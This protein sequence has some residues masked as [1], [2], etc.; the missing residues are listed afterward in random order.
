[1]AHLLEKEQYVK[2][3]KLKLANKKDL[4]CIGRI[5]FPVT[6]LG[7]G[8]RL[9]IW[10]RGC[11]LMCEECMS[12]DLWDVNDK[13]YMS[14]LDVYNIILEYKN[15]IDGLTISGGEPF[16]QIKSLLPLIKQLFE[17]ITKDIILYTGY[18]VKELEENYFYEYNEIKKYISVLITGRYIKEMNNSIGLAGSS[19]QEYIT[20]NNMYTI[21]ELKNYKREIN[22]FN[23][24]NSIVLVGILNAEKGE[25]DDE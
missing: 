22:I 23:F 12:K 25:N 9:V 13:S 19:N 11:D 20:M 10:L 5:I 1:M 15:K 18:T 21:D 3:T 8:N 16:L 2:S 4:L 24:N 17:N 7:Y 6:S 14:V